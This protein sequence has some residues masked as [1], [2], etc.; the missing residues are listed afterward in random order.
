MPTISKKGIQMPASPIRKLTPFAD[1]A[2]REGKKIYH[3]N[4][5]QPDIE[6][7]EVML[8][9]LKNIDFKVW[10]YTPSEGTLSYR[11]KLAEYYNKINYNISP[12]DIL[13]TNGGSEAITIAMQAC[14]NPGEE[15]IIPE[16]FYANY[17][18]FAC[19]ADIIV[20]PIMSYIDN[21]FALPSIAEFE[22]VITEKTKAIAICNPNNPT[23]YLYSREELEALR[24]LCL[25]YDL[26]L[27]SDE[28]YREFCYDG[29]EFL[30]PMHLEGLEN[31]VVVFD[32][33]SKRYSACGARIGCII[34]KNNEL[35]QTCL[36]FAQARLSP[37]L[38]GQIAG[39]AAVD[40][41]DSYFEA[42]SKEYTARR[43]VLVAG[44]NSIDGVF[45]PNPGG[46]FY[47]VAKLPID[48]ADKFCQWILEEFDYNNETVMMAPATGFYSTPGAGQNEVRL[49]Y[50]LNQDDLKKAL[51]CLEEALKAY[52]LR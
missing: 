12:S 8:N 42:V 5:G 19:S 18:G 34:T 51:K 39:E 26:Y 40:T 38:E 29:R 44:L 15:V 17:N 2:K 31:N 35:Y 21:G 49:A 1:Q 28:A 50:V 23:G 33:V 27:F 30:S 25:K 14:L 13:V 6:T 45:C 48:N 32:T 9:A 4:I 24:E 3:L 20:K 46:A 47:V 43:D 22:K 36:K 16:P 11:T 52:S 7:P 10:A 41:P 37:S